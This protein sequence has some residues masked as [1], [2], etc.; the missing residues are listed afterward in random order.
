MEDVE[1]EVPA[2]GPTYQQCADKC[3]ELGEEC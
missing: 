3:S 2:P 1:V